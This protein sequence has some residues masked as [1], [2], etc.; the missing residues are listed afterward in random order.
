MRVARNRATLS[1]T[2]GK[3]CATGGDTRS[4]KSGACVAA[5]TSGLDITDQ[6]SQSGRRWSSEGRKLRRGRLSLGGIGYGSCIALQI[7]AVK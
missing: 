2:L 7:Y 4:P 3:V 1:G 5:G 6:E